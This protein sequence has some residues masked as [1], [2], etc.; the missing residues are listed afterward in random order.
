MPRVGNDPRNGS[1]E[2]QFEMDLPD[3]RL[4]FLEREKAS[5]LMPH[6]GQRW[7]LVFCAS[8]HEGSMA[9]NP[10]LTHVFFLCD[11]CFYTKGAPPECE[12]VPGT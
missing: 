7:D 12:Q 2:R 8:C 11:K 6:L 5:V 4:S 3:C 10:G 9:C 1:W